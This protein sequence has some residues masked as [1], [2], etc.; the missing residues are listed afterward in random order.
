MTTATKPRPK[1]KRRGNGEGSIY[2][3]GD[4]R[5]VGSV[6]LGRDAKGKRIR[7]TI[8]GKT[9]T[10]AQAEL[11]KL[12]SQKAVGTLKKADRQTVAEYLTAWLES[13]A[14]PSI[15][16]ATFLNYE[17]SANKHIIPAIGHLSVTKLTPQQI[18]AMYS[19]MEH[20]GSSG[21]T[22]KL[23]HAVL[24]MALKRAVKWGIVLRNACDA[25]EAPRLPET[26]IHPLS[27]EQVATF[28][29]AI[30]DSDYEALFLLAIGAGLRI[31]EIRLAA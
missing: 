3:R 22:R 5:W 8:Y 6:T 28:I 11:S 2:L 18:Q 26:D 12:Q 4:G 31:G 23:A 15:D 7:R 21:Y 9:K 10:E 16:A 14:R 24:S 20:N 25:V 1:T 30:R 19:M 27:A 17:T 29:E 13:C